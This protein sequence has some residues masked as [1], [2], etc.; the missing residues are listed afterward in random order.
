LNQFIEFLLI[1]E[2]KLMTELLSAAKFI[3][4]RAAIIGVAGSGAGIG[5]EFNNTRT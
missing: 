4:A 1:E 5:T 2:K 3:G